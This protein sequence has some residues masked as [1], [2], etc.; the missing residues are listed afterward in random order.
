MKSWRTKVKV[1]LDLSNYATKA[2]LKNA[3]GVVTSFAEKTDIAN[4]KSVVNKL[5]IDKLKKCTK[6]FKQLEKYS[7]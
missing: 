6:W 1:V 2:D 4:L 5:D 7:R 3:T